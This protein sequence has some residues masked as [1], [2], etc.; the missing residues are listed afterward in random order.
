MKPYLQTLQMEAGGISF[1]VVDNLCFPA[2]WHLPCELVYVMQ[3]TL[4]VGVNRTAYELVQGDM[5]AVG[6]NNIHYYSAQ[7]CRMLLIIFHPEIVGLAQ[8]WP[9]AGTFAQ[10]HICAQL[11]EERVKRLLVWSAEHTDMDGLAKRGI[12]NLLCA[13]VQEHA[14]PMEEKEADA[15]PHRLVQEAIGYIARNY[16]EEISLSQIAGYVNMSKYYFSRKFKEYTGVSIPQHVNSVRLCHAEQMLEE[17]GRSISDIAYECG[18]GSLRNF[19]RAFF[20]KN[21]MTPAEFRR[22]ATHKRK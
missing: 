7:N 2:H 18:F 17:S 6:S 16:R 15:A 8:G 21:N 5:L 12:V 4:T 3:G 11:V 14:A 13:F 1:G 22:Q 9:K 19:N 20:G 10:P